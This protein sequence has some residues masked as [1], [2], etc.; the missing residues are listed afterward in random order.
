MLLLASHTKNLALDLFV[1]YKD[2]SMQTQI[3]L[4]YQQG[5]ILFKSPK[6]SN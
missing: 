3:Q 1:R 2:V 6:K 4:K 5:R